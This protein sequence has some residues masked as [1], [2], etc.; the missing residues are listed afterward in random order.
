MSASLVQ[1]LE[2]QSPHFFPVIADLEKSM[3]APLNL[4]AT[5]KRFS[6]SI[7]ANLDAFDGFIR[8]TMLEAGA[9]FLFGGYGEDRQ[10]YRRSM[11]FDKNISE[12]S[13]TEPRSLHLGLDIWG[14][15]GTEIRAPL[16]GMLHSQAFND[17]A[18][19]YGGTIILSHQLEGVSFYCLYGHLAAADVHRYRDGQFI[20]RGELVGVFGKPAEN[21]HWPPHLHFQLIA[22]IGVHEGD[23][24]GVCKPSE[25][26]QY[27]LNSPDPAPFFPVLKKYR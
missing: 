5:N 12:T 1:L 23:Y 16:G 22:D 19:D 11:L 3:A 8:Q 13:S 24:P 4:S 7:Y 27:L 26:R 10:M 25:S 9:A 14:P 20:N 18:G 2:Q 21:G 6:E 15:A 17:R